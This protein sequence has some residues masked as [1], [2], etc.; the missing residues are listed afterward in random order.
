[1]DQV[2]AACRLGDQHA[3]QAV[4]RRYTLPEF[5]VFKNWPTIRYFYLSIQLAHY[6]GLP[7]GFFL[8]LITL[9]VNT[10]L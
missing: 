7:N 8:L 5:I 9:F 3:E 6:N 1:M 2:R 10:I 4:R